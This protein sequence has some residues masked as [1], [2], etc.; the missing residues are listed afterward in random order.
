MLDYP[1]LS[2]PGKKVARAYG[3]V[4]AKRTLPFRHTIYIGKNGKILFIDKKVKA[5]SHGKDVA[6]KLAELGV[7]KAK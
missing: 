5:R 6:K 2:D 7:A 1:I 3:V 4:T